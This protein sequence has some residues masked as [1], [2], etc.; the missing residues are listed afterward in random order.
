MS[1]PDC[2]RMLEQ[3]VVERRALDLDGFR[4][5]IEFAL[6]ENKARAD[7][8]RCPVRTA[9]HIFAEN[10]PPATRAARPFAE[11]GHVA[12]QQRFADVEARENFLFQ[13]QHAFAR[14]RQ[15]G[16][17]AAAAGTATDHQ[18]VV[19]ILIHATSLMMWRMMASLETG[20]PL[21]A[22]RR[23][24]P[25]CFPPSAFSQRPAYPKIADLNQRRNFNPA[26]GHETIFVRQAH[27]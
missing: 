14:P 27:R 23:R 22:S 13:H 18:R 16:G 1:A 26:A 20:D 3:N 15:K 25:G 6:P 4:L 5:A 19:S 9:R 21:Q 11:N 7:A 17:G 24:T 10:P 12:G 2:A 8:S